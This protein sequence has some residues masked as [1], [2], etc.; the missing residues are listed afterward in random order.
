MNSNKNCF[1]FKELVDINNMAPLIIQ[2]V[3]NNR[4]VGHLF[5]GNG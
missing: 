3:G 4:N 2:F 5:D 1:W